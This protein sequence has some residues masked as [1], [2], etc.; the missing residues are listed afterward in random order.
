MLEFTELSFAYQK[1][2]DANRSV[3]HVLESK[4]RGIWQTDRGKYKQ[5][6][7]CNMRALLVPLN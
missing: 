4:R 3:F 5:T 1:C 2:I 6:E 7:F